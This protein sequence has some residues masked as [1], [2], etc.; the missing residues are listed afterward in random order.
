[1]KMEIEIENAIEIAKEEIMNPDNLTKQDIQ[2]F[3]RRL[4]GL[5]NKLEEDA[6]DGDED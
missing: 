1:M 2:D 4:N 5:L 6:R 3:R